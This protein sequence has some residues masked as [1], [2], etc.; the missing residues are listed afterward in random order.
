MESAGG[1]LPA[2]LAA[3]RAVYTI[4]S[5]PAA[6]VITAA[7]FGADRGAGRSGA[8]FEVTAHAYELSGPEEVAAWR[9]L[10]LDRLIV[11]PW[12]RSRDAAEGLARFAAEYEVS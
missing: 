7:R 5:G 11:R 12:R 9:E 10:G 6:G 8:P 1:V 2:A 4:E 3:S